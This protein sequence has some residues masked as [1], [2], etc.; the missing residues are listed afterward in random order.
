MGE[1]SEIAPKPVAEDCFEWNL[2]GWLRNMKHEFRCVFAPGYERLGVSCANISRGT[3]T[4]GLTGPLSHT[5]E[6][7]AR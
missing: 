3:A 5:V 1:K 7:I 4:F 2:S 6:K